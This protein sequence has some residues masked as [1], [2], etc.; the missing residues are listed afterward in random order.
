MGEIGRKQKKAF[1][2]WGIGLG[3]IA[4]GFLLMGISGS[5][6]AKIFIDD[7]D[8]SLRWDNTIRYNYGVRVRSP[9]G[10]FLN[11]PNYDDGDRNFSKG[12]VTNRLD[13]MS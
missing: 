7:E 3:L 12:T 10:C 9:H 6:D 2:F 8:L 11:S 4:A 13:L 1:G 5:A